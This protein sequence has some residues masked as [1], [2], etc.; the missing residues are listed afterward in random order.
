M[1]AVVGSISCRLCVVRIGASRFYI[2]Q[3][4]GH[5]RSTSVKVVVIVVTVFAG[6]AG[7]AVGGGLFGG[8]IGTDLFVLTHPPLSSPAP[9]CWVD[10]E[11]FK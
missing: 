9:P 1:H 8:I 3:A 10:S 11:R 2:L 5:A 7:A 4:A 6:V